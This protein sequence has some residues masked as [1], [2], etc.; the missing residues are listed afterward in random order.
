MIIQN[1]SFNIIPYIKPGLIFWLNSF[2]PKNDGTIFSNG[3]GISTAKSK[4]HNIN[5]TQANGSKQ[6]I[7]SWNS[8]Q[9]KPA[10]S[11]NGT[12]QS[13][14]VAGLNNLLGSTDITMFFLFKP[15]T[16]SG[17]RWLLDT[18]AGGSRLILS[19][20]FLTSTAT[21]INYTA[22]TA[23][24]LITAT[25]DATNNLMTLYKDGVQ[26][27]TAAYAGRPFSATTG[28]GADSPASFGHFSGLIIDVLFYRGV[29]NITDLTD[30]NRY[31]A[32]QTGLN[33]A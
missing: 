26:V 23:L 8:V 12:N 30:V 2:D 16:T 1:K 4:S 31:L 22:T 11:F 14:Q 17:T 10:F 20:S 29:L 24:Q 19:N 33:I 15:D 6:P 9:G 25:L 28:I 18:N 13:F 3:E 5:Y 7:Y 32:N 21:S 27:G